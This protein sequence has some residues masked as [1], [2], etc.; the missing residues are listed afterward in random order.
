[1]V[2]VQVTSIGQVSYT[3]GAG[4]GLLLCVYLVRRW[5]E[6]LDHTLLFVA[7][8]MSTLWSGWAAYQIS[9]GQ[10]LSAVLYAL[11]ALRDALWLIFLLQLISALFGQ[12]KKTDILLR[13]AI[14]VG[15]ST[16]VLLLFSVLLFPPAMFLGAPFGSGTSLLLGGILL[17]S[18]AGLV[19]VEQLFRNI[20]REQSAYVRYLCLALGGVFVYDIFM[21]LNALFEGRINPD[22]WQARGL[23]NAL[24]LA[25]IALAVRNPLWSR[26]IY[27]SHAAIF[28]S[29]GVV[30]VVLYLMLIGAGGYYV[31]VYG[32]SW[33]KVGQ[34]VLI[35]AALMFL[36][37]LLGSERLRA[38]LKIFVSKNFFRYKYDYREEWLR[39]IRVLSRGGAG[40]HLPERAIQ[41]I[42]QIVDASA[43]MLWLR[44]EAGSYHLVTKWKLPDLPVE[45]VSAGGSLARFLEHWQWVIN[46][47]EYENEPEIYK[48]LELPEWISAIP[49]A[50]LV[51][52]LMQDVQLLGF[53]VV[54]RPR[55]RRKI[56]WE[57]H[58]LLKTAGRQAATQ[59]AQMM[60]AQALIEAR[61]FFTFSRLSAFVMHDLKNVIGQLSLLI[62]NAVKFQDNP[63]FMADAVKT[64]EHS[65]IKMNRLLAQLSKGSS[66]DKVKV[67]L[68][69]LLGEVIK[70]RRASKPLPELESLESELHVSANRDRL[71]AVIEHIVQNAQEATPVDGWVKVR[72]SCTDR[73]ACLEIED[74]GCGMDA[75]FIRDRLF[76]PFDTTKGQG[77]MG[78]GAFET[79][80][81]V[82]ELGGDI[83]VRS[84]P[85]VGTLFRICLPLT[86]GAETFNETSE[87]NR[88]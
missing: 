56:N 50:W 72:L 80:D 13:L 76:R 12:A 30:A 5:R 54:A 45:S 83:Y 23:V 2:D 3:A 15:L 21:Y 62:T 17:L 20:P 86:E 64:I 36:L 37:A 32:G 28:Y 46:L 33:G 31:R 47:D 40:A 60:A 52:P 24:A 41:A 88:D 69:A 18:V 59:L 74:G 4:A 42:A 55:V 78:V 49:E 6:R 81:Y 48:E 63:Q 43:G 26:A 87:A 58:D 34:V 79:R 9:K 61:E 19:A 57:D 25:P 85:G 14:A 73:R 66:R 35:A 82:R 11:E 39:F 77:G 22:F 75:K 7:A 53:I 71:A 68:A 29:L 84:E 38:N 44:A 70:A 51:V 27:V 1:M 10:A 16:L 67:D 65:V 8:A